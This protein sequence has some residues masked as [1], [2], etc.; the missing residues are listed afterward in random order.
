MALRFRLLALVL[1]LTWPAAVARA[2]VLVRWDLDQVPSPASLGITTVLIPASRPAAVQDALARGYRVYLDV[3]AAAF[4]DVPAPLAP[5]AGLVVRGE[6]SPQQIDDLLQRLRAPGARVRRIDG[7]GLWP[8]VRLHQVA[9]RNNVLQ[10][11]SRS[12]QPWLDSNAVFTRIAAAESHGDAPLLLAPAWEPVTQSDTDRGPGVEAYLVAIAESGSF[13]NDL[14]LPLHAA[15]ER[16]LLL[17]D[18]EARTAWQQIRAYL[19]FYAWEL[20]QRYRR[21]PNVG[22]IAADAMGSIEVLRLLTRH[23]LPF[24]LVT[25]DA[26]NTEGLRRFAAIVAL[27]PL[28]EAQVSPL[29]AFANGGGTIVLN[30]PPGGRQWQ[31]ATQ[32]AKSARHVT[33]RV[34]EGRVVELA[35]PVT[36]P[37]EFALDLRNIIGPERRVVD[38]WNG[39][40]VLVSPYEDGV[41]GAM[42]VTLV[43]YAHGS[44][45]VQVRV[46][47][48]FTRAQYESPESEPV[49]LP[50][51]LHNGFTEFVV[52]AQRVGG[53][54]FL[55]R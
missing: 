34:G 27:D 4:A 1:L 12:A 50:V 26:L 8:E 48:A 55:T 21:V 42:L 11:S 39:I 45:A 10:V 19:E 14:V 31:G 54:V 44:Q 23:N 35:E 16:R 43:D 28:K 13:G 51:R 46:K 41:S 52:P 47:G 32:L 33:Y 38:V 36:D 37:D 49:L 30:G 40:T 5:V 2:E 17:G 9:L 29:A 24:E 3:E 22:V 7:R 18:P 25:P 15:F 53:R 20:P 6:A